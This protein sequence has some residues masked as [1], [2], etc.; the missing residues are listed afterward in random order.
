MSTVGLASGTLVATG[1]WI[2]AQSPVHAD[3]EEKKG[4]HERHQVPLSALLR[5]YVVYAMCSIPALVDYSPVVLSTLMS[6]PGIKQLTEAVVRITF[7]DQVSLTL[8]VGS[9]RVEHASDS[10]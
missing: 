2:A 8:F 5:T 6:V 10:S 7:F 3:T 9:G 1:L 4:Q